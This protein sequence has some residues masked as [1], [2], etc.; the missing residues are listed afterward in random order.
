[1]RALSRPLDFAIVGAAKAGTSSLAD[2]LDAHPQAQ[3]LRPKDGHFFAA[4]DGHP[5]WQGPHDA[6]FNALI[7]RAA[8]E[9]PRQA[10][11]A[12]S[13]TLVGDASVFYMTDE[14]ALSHLSDHLTEV[15]P[16]ICILR[17]PEERAY[18]AYMHLVREQRETLSFGDA[19][20]AEDERRAGR[21]HPLWWYRELGMYAAQLQRIYDVFGTERTLVLRYDDIQQRPGAVAAQV[22]HRLGLPVP[23]GLMI[24][25]ANASGVPRSQ[26]LQAGLVSTNPAKRAL[27]RVVPKKAW[28]AIR[29]RLQAAN[30]RR[31][32]MPQAART[33]LMEDYREDV[34]RV[35]AMTGLDLAGWRSAR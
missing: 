11:A 9:F 7:S 22:F 2:A 34:D 3:V 24:G 17:R 31:V 13:D 18:S 30:L 26:W 6:S 28:L 21:W 35:E 25:H 23:P 14:R 5:Q 1:M 12:S 32:E 29:T 16:I 33:S 20:A 27:G 4:L 15:A 19:L 8:R 10:E